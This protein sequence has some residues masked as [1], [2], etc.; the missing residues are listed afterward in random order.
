MKKVV[1]LL[2][3]LALAALIVVGCGKIPST[4]ITTGGGGGCSTGQTVDMASATFVQ[5]CVNAK[6][7]VPFT[8]NDPASSGG[9]HIICIGHDQAC[10][11]GATG[12]KDLLGN[13]FQ[14]VQGQTKVVTFTTPGTYDITCTVHPN[15]NVTVTVS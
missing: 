1:L 12:P 11:A 2:V 10:K 5:T 6:V 15:M 7:N 8:F 4:G 14:I 13:G 3:P 9:V